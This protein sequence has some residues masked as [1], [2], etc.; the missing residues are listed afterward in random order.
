MPVFR[1]FRRFRAFTLIELLV[2]IAI[3][4]ILIGLLLPAVQ[5]VRDAAARAQCQNNLRQISLAMINCAG[6]NQNYLPPGL[7]A[8]P[9]GSGNWGGGM[10][11]ILPYIEQQNIFNLSHCGS[12]T[13][14]NV[15]SCAAPGMPG[16]GNHAYDYTIKSYQ[17]PA[18]PTYLTGGVGTPSNGGGWGITSY[19]MNGYLFMWGWSGPNVQYP[20]YITDGTSN[21][22]FFTE[23]YG[24]DPFTWSNYFFNAIWWWDY[25]VFEGGGQYGTQCGGDTGYVGPAYTPL[26]APSV[27]WCTSPANTYPGYGPGNRL[28][29][30]N[31]RAI[32]SHAGVINL[33]M[34]DGSVRTTSGSISGSTWMYACEPQD[35]FVLGSDW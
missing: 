12:G 1:L 31:C 20:A 22:I 23:T 29:I 3:I 30:C 2:V 21:T 25:N 35:G 32:S 8:Y 13:S 6:T 18:D 34:A 14:Y 11:Y 5:K 7:G 26:I 24:F 10:Y 9:A 15:E 16:W 19:D 17:C 28:F 33:A 4:A 27:N